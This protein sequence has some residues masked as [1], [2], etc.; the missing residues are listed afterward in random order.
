MGRWNESHDGGG[1]RAGTRAAGAG[2]E[3]REGGGVTRAAG[4]GT[5]SVMTM[6]TTALRARVHVRHAGA[7]TPIVWSHVPSMVIGQAMPQMSPT[8]HVWANA[9][10]DAKKNLEGFGY[11]PRRSEEHST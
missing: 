5:T 4:S 9:I 2:T 8:G 10:A 3:R 11:G 7:C 1:R 6:G